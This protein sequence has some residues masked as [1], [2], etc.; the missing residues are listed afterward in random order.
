[1]RFCAKNSRL[2]PYS[3]FLV[4]YFISFKSFL[5]VAPEE[6]KLLG[7]KVAP[8]KSRKSGLKR[9]Q[10]KVTYNVSKNLNQSHLGQRNP[11]KVS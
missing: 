1:M 3:I 11:S 10:A 6:K 8:K 5:K 2:V 7:A 9:K 4:I